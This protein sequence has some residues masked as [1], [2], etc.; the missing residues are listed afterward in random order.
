MHRRASLSANFA[1][2]SIGKQ[3]ALSG[4]DC[5]SDWQNNLFSQQRLMSENVLRQ[6]ELA[7]MGIRCKEPAI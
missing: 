7:I 6:R 3:K 5:S 2:S 4:Y 1:D